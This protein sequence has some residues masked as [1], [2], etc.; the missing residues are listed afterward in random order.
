VSVACSSTKPRRRVRSRTRNLTP[1]ITETAKALWF[2]YLAITVVG[3]VALHI[4][5][6]S[7]FDAIC[8]CFSAIGLG[9][10]GTHDNNVNYFDSPAV[11]FVIICIMLVASMNFARHFMAFRTLSLKPYL[12]DSEGKAI[13]ITVSLAV[14]VVTFALWMNQCTP[15]SVLHCGTPPSPWCRSPPRPALSRLT[16]KNGRSSVAPLL[17]LLSSVTCSTGST[18]GGIKMFRTL[19]LGRHGTRA[20][21]QLIHPS[22]IIPVRIGGQVIP[23]RIVYSVLAFIFL[24]FMTTCADL[25]HAVT[26]L[27][28]V[29]SFSA[30][31]G[32]I[33][34]M[35][36]AWARI[37]P[38]SN[39]SVLS[40]AQNLDLLRQRCCSGA[41]RSSASWCCSRRRSGANSRG[42][43]AYVSLQVRDRAFLLSMTARTRS[44]METMPMT[45][46]P[47]TTGR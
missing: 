16:T 19:L 22:A 20:L 21:K 40:D 34:N 18:G 43:A 5:G 44:P 10:F 39:F 24:Y 9:G 2:T 46:S 29:S 47:D 15:I 14:A 4:A 30:V 26:G 35:G 6:M 33:N 27:D 31:I 3:I 13:F 17:L 32:S 38:A 8:H 37:G 28:F 1:R 23:D 41:W 7:W 42:S 12:R 11:E 45:W 36:P 25:R